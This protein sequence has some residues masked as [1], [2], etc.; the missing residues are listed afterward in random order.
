VSAKTHRNSD[1]T[2]ILTLHFFCIPKDSR[3]YVVIKL[4]TSVKTLP[5]GSEEAGSC[6][7]HIFKIGGPSNM[8]ALEIV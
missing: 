3:N 6:R 4:I 5:I 7:R 8:A 1:R 2:T